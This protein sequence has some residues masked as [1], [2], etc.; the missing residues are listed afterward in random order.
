[1][2][3]M[4]VYGDYIYMSGGF[5]NGWKNP[6]AQILN[7]KDYTD[8]KSSLELDET[9]GSFDFKVANNKVYFAFGG[10]SF[11]DAS[12]LNGKIKVY[13]DD[14][15]PTIS[16]VSLANDNSTIAVTMS[17]AVFNTNSGSG[18]L[19]ASDFSFSLSGGVATLSS[20]TPT[21]ISKNGNVYTLGIGLSGTPTGNETLTVNPVDDS[22]YDG[23]GKEASTDQSNN[24]VK[25]NVI[26]AISSTTIVDDNS[27][28][29]VT[30]SAPVYNTNGASGNLEVSDFVLSIS[31]GVATL[32]SA[33]PT[34]IERIGYGDAKS[35]VDH[36]SGMTSRTGWTNAWQTFTMGDE[37][38]LATVKLQ[39]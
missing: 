37:G 14:T 8:I 6:Q 24:T 22:I 7:I 9:L 13:G 27:T 5:N 25:L 34:S 21:S 30:I 20:A 38:A 2:G 12:L 39:L 33:T 26:A 16:S 1:M 19:E 35:L 29:T 11:A 17:E 10:Q 28:I 3:E 32:G 23:T 31:G 36:S 15:P 4:E 18:A